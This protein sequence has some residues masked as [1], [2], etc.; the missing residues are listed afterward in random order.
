MPLLSTMMTNACS[1]DCH[2][3]PMRAS[4]N[5]PRYSFSPEELAET[6]MALKKRNRAE[7]FSSPAAF[8]A[9]ASPAWTG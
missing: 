4:R 1:Y 3:C 9:M 2:Y 7:G 6:F 8:P 5:M